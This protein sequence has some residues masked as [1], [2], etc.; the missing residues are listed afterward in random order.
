MPFQGTTFTS[1][2]TEP[3]MAL[4]PKELPTALQPSIFQPAGLIPTLQTLTAM[5]LGVP[6]LRWLAKLQM[7]L[8]F[9]RQTR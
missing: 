5:W 2:Q 7:L 4:R 9:P 6:T 8:T 3:P 1:Q